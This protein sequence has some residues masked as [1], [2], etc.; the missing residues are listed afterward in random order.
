MD[1][2]LLQTFRQSVSRFGIISADQCE[3]IEGVSS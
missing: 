3:Q 2:S 1:K